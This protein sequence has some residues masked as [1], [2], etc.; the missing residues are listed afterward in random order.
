MSLF[1]S[2]VAL[3]LARAASAARMSG[4]SFAASLR[5]SVDLRASY[6]STPVPRSPWVEV[7]ARVRVR[8][9]KLGVREGSGGTPTLNPNT[10]EYQGGWGC[11]NFNAQTSFGTLTQRVELVVPDV[12]PPPR[13]DFLAHTVPPHRFRTPTSTPAPPPRPRP[14]RLDPLSHRS[15]V[16][17]LR[18]RYL[19]LEPDHH[20]GLVASVWRWESGHVSRQ[21]EFIWIYINMELGS[22]LSCLS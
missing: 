10:L 20:L 21:S 16:P 11:S 9:S 3:A 17:Y 12:L 7:G 19:V 13:S 5:G 18:F 1:L 22:H 15:P 2:V 4:Y 14:L 8:M 6:W